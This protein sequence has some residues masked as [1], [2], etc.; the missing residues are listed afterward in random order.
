MNCHMAHD[1]MPHCILRVS[2]LKRRI[3]SQLI[4]ISQETTVNL[5]CTCQYLEELVFVRATL[6]PTVFQV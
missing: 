2:E 5:A 3:V 4:L 1:S 6:R